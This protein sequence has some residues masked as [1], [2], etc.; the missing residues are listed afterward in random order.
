MK[1]PLKT[2][3]FKLDSTTRKQ[4]EDRAKRNGKTPGELARELVLRAL[5]D[6]NGADLLKVKM[7]SLES[8]VKQLRRGLSNSVEALLVVSGKV[9]KEE[10]KHWVKDKIG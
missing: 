10:A 4:L 2:V 7:S 6:E 3:G 5:E 8:E 9:T 1:E